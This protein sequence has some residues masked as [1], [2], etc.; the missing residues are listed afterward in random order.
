LS[1][2]VTISFG[3]FAASGGVGSFDDFAGMVMV[4][5]M[6]ISSLKSV[7]MPELYGRAPKK[8]SSVPV[9][10]AGEAD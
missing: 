8:G 7:R 2:C 5:Q 4:R 9:S 6:T 3:F 10:V 1:P